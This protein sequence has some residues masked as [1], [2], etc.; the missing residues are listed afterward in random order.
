M[1]CLSE[2]DLVLF[3]LGFFLIVKEHIAL[4]LV[5]DHLP[6]QGWY[7]CQEFFANSSAVYELLMK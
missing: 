2:A 7:F 1:F 5:A 3:V 4:P 6:A